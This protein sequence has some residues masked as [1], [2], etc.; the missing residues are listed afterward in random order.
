LTPPRTITGTIANAPFVRNP[1]WR[2]IVLLVLI[3]F[4]GI[5]TLFPEQYRAATSLTPSEPSSL[6]LSGTLGQLG[7]VNSVFGNQAAIEVALKVARSEFVRGTVSKQLKLQQRLGKNDVETHRWLESKMDIRSLKGGIIQFAIKNRDPDLAR[8]IISA[9]SEAVR[10]QLG[11]IA[12][13]QT[14]YKRQIL[15]ELV[16]KASD[17]LAVAQTAYD[18]FRLK[19]RYSSPQAAIYAAGDRIPEMEAMIRSKQVQLAQMRQFA[20]DDNMRIRQVVAEIEA[21]QSQLESARSLKPSDPSSVGQVVRQS[22]EVDRLRRELT[23]AQTLYD[24]YKKYLQGTSVE[25]L[26]SSANV[27]V[28]EPAY[29]DTARQ[30]N[31]FPLA[32]MLALIILGGA[33]EFYTLRPPLLERGLA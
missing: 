23:L 26:T 22:T 7:A 4:F 10:N 21:L 14:A 16:E 8:H 20:T 18:T 3:I 13:D 15:L 28:L 33:I 24:N 29:I 25:D 32:I 30:V 31:V 1:L 5:L 2:R 17:R 6:G 19:T 27:R 11:V 9:Y 12:R